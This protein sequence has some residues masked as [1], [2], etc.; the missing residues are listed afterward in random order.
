MARIRTIKPEFFTSEDIVSLSPLARL[1]YVSLWCEAD[2]EGRLEWKPK[3]LKMRYLPSDNCDVDALG[4]ELVDGGLIH[5]YEVDGRTYAAIPGFTRHQVINN[6]ESESNIPSPVDNKKP[7]VKVAS[8]RVQGE[9]KEGRE[10]KGKERKEQ[11][12]RDVSSR[13]DDFWNS[14]PANERKQD[15]AKCCEKW[16]KD[17]LDAIADT[18]LADITT[19]RQTQKWQQ[20]YIE[21][22]LVY[23]NNK[24]W[25]DGVTPQAKDAQGIAKDWWETRTGIEDM[26]EVLELGRWDEERE[27]WFP[28][29]N[30][31][32]A[33]ARAEGLLPEGAEL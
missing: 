25:E 21:A 17:K 30:R 20:G 26:G 7:R 2:R 8:E 28:Y 23:L 33:K 16:A 1:F 18:I 9:G 29:R 31:V 32:A 13:F 11:P 12:T 3:T 22:P 6:R 14:W 24:R 19:K 10:G 27:Q 15:R 5:L 4:T